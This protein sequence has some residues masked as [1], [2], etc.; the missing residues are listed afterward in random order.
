MTAPTEPIPPRSE[1]FEETAQWNVAL[2]MFGLALLVAIGAFFVLL[3]APVIETVLL[4][5]VFAFIFHAVVRLAV[6]RYHRL[7]YGVTTVT[8]YL[9]VAILFLMAIVTFGS[10]LLNNGRSVIQSIQSAASA[11]NTGSTDSPVSGISDEIADALQSAGIPDAAQVTTTIL[12]SIVSR[13]SWGLSS[14]VGFVGMVGI[15]LIFAFMLQMA[16]Y[17]RKRGALSWVPPSYVREVS[18]MMSKLDNTWA[19]YLI[20]GVA[21]ASVL[22][23]LSLIQYELMGVPYALVLAILTGF[24]TLIPSIGGLLASVIVFFACLT[25]GSTVMTGIDNAAFALLVL[26][27]NVPITQGTYYFVGL[28]LTGRGVRLPIAIVFIGSLAGLSTGSLLIAWLTV[29]MIATMRIFSSY[30]LAKV[31]GRTA[32]PGE[33]IPV[34]AE[35]GFLSRM[36]SPSPDTD[37]EGIPEHKP[38]T[39]EQPAH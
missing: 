36:F 9:A 34:G 5:F 29:P 4:A 11:I 37:V 32:F 3:F 39:L 10:D 14:L 13:L 31:S 35:N 27:I 38:Q 7:Q 23:L 8:L 22:A 20:A 18:V 16:I 26:L 30:L 1:A 12:Q 24:L 19:G 2:R 28:P 15:A 6:R 17:S 21:F 25:L 33:E